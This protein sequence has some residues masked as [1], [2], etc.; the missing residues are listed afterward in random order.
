MELNRLYYN[1]HLTVELVSVHTT[2]LKTL[3]NISILRRLDSNK[4]TKDFI[5]VCNF[6]TDNNKCNWAF[7]YAYD[8][9]SLT[10][11][12]KLFIDKIS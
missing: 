3:S 7:A 8:I 2:D 12:T 6:K 11:A 1:N 9:P 10:E 5:V 4:Q